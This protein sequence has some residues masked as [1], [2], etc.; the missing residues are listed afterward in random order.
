MALCYPYDSDNFIS[1]LQEARSLID[2]SN[3]VAKST[4]RGVNINFARHYIQEGRFNDA[5][6]ELKSAELI[7]METFGR[8]LPDTQ[9][10]INKCLAK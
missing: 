10:L 9:E 3:E 7:E 5:I 1:Y 4:L 2:N 8:I 6:A